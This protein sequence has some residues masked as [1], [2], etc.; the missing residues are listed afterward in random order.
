MVMVPDGVGHQVES[1]AVGGKAV[2]IGQT[3]KIS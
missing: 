1:G 3:K 2:R